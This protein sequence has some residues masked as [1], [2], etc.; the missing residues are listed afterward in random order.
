MNATYPHQTVFSSD[1]IDRSYSCVSTRTTNKTIIRRCQMGTDGHDE[2]CDFRN[3]LSPQ[4][5]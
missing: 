2:T 4:W 5:I 1:Y 3:S